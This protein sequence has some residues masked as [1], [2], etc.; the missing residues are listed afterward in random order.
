MRKEGWACAVATLASDFTLAAVVMPRV[1]SWCTR[2]GGFMRCRRL[3]RTLLSRAAQRCG[4]GVVAPNQD[5]DHWRT[6]RVGNSQA[7]QTNGKDHSRQC[8]DSILPSSDQHLSHQLI[9]DGDAVPDVD[10]FMSERRRHRG[11]IPAL[12][13]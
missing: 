8:C 12:D 10:C 6:E 7:T 11:R 1:R 13:A 9:G 2:V 3:R 4:G 5:S